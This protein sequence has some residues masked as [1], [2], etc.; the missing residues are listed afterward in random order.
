MSSNGDK[1][2]ERVGNLNYPQTAMTQKLYGKLQMTVS[3]KADGSIESIRIHQSSGHRILDESARR[4][5]Q[6]AA[7]F[8]VFSE[9]IR[10]DTDVLSITRTW[11]FSKD[12][13]LSTE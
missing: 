7:P 12:D 5:V 11:T 4:I 1:K 6:L 8:P 13:Q 10:Q 3:V 2:I 9:D